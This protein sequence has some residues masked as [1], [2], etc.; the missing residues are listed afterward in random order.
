MHTLKRDFNDI[1]KTIDENDQMFPRHGKT[2]D[3]NA[4]QYFRVGRS[5]LDAIKFAMQMSNKEASDITNILDFACGHGRVMRHLR[6]AFPDSNITA[7]DYTEDGIKFCAK[8]F[9][10]TP[11]LSSQDASNIHFED[12]FDLIWVGSFFTHLPLESF[13]SFVNLL[14]N[15]LKKHGLLVFTTAGNKVAKIVKGG[16]Y[17]GY[18]PRHLEVV[19]NHF[20][21]LGF[22][23]VGQEKFSWKWGRAIIKPSWLLN[24]L[25]RFHDLELVF[26]SEHLWANRQ[27][28]TC[29][30]LR[31]SSKNTPF[32]A[33]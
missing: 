13:D 12:E 32:P 11:V 10:A 26:F 22:G 24:R 31:G 18:D 27:D 30:Q 15:A 25:E 33:Q 16:E 29:L 5:A 23:W 7:C 19:V 17:G 9:E 6:A 1:N 2:Y 8:E 20:E 4:Q 14:S 3:E 28:V 21:E